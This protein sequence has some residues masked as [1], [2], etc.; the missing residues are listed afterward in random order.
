[1]IR[2]RAETICTVSANI[3]G[4]NTS[5][6][7]ILID[8]DRNRIGSLMPRERGL[9]IEPAGVFFHGANKTLYLA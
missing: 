8:E 4:A 7:V 3:T 1:M 6:E 2:V 5:V 9:F